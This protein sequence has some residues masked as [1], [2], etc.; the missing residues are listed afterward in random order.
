[1]LPL[2]APCSDCQQPLTIRIDSRSHSLGY[3][4]L[5]AEGAA[6]VMEALKTNSTLQILKYAPH[7]RIPTV[8]SR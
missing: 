4:N 6:H 2:P 3:N 7:T 1:M 8:S 5:K